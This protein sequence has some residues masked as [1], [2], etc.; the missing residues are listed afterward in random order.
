MF[1]FV[2]P[3]TAHT[4]LDDSTKSKYLESIKQKY[5]NGMLRS[6]QTGI[7]LEPFSM[8]GWVKSSGDRTNPKFKFDEMGPGASAELVDYFWNKYYFEGYLLIMLL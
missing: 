4:D 5:E 6:M 8:R 1:G 7:R 3:E 2:N